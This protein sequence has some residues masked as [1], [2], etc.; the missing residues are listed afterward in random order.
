M[1]KIVLPLR[2]T[3]LSSFNFWIGDALRN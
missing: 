3:R 2:Q 1:L